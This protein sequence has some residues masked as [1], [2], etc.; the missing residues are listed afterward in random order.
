MFAKIIFFFELA[1]LKNATLAAVVAYGVTFFLSW[2]WTQSLPPLHDFT[3]DRE[4]EAS[5]KT[6][7]GN[8]SIA[9]EERTSAMTEFYNYP[10]LHVKPEPIV[11]KINKLGSELADINKEIGYLKTLKQCNLEHNRWVNESQKSCS[12]V[13]FVTLTAITFLGSRNSY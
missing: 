5:L 4:I 8:R 10:R 1:I 13:T 7:E 6:L 2:V 9:F 11:I 3:L 12:K